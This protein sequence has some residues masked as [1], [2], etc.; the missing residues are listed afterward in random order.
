MFQ[1]YKIRK[2]TYHP[3]TYGVILHSRFSR[4][5]SDRRRYDTRV[6]VVYDLCYLSVV[7]YLL[8]YL[9]RTCEVQKVHWGR[10]G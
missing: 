10:R 7:L 5:D 9:R 8:T 4:P 2:G 3:Q 1:E 6:V